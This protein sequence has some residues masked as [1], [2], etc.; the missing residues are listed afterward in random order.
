MSIKVCN[1][2]KQELPLDRFSKNKSRSD[3]LNTYCKECVRVRRTKFNESNP[4][5]RREYYL[6]NKLRIQ[7]HTENWKNRHKLEVTKYQQEY[8]AKNRDEI[9]RKRRELNALRKAN[10]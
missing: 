7:E 1:D 9:N 5:Y 2:C 4:G 8:Y 3:E 6:T 10:R